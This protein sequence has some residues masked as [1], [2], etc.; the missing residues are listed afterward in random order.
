MYRN[1][2]KFYKDLIENIPS[3]QAIDLTQSDKNAI[4]DLKS[5]IDDHIMPIWTQAI[6]QVGDQIVDDQ[7]DN[8]VFSSDENKEDMKKVAKDWLHKNLMYG[9]ITAVTSYVYNYSHSSNPIIT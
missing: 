3:E 9:D 2:I 4:A 1:S 6:M 8:E 7:I 5:L